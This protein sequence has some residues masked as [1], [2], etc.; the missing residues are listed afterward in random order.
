MADTATRTMTRAGRRVPAPFGG[1]PSSGTRHP[2]VA[3]AMVLPL[4]ALLVVVFG[5]WD[6]VVTQASSV[7]VML[8]R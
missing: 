4:A 5:G 7:G 6:A 1:R 3:T 8:G 2:L